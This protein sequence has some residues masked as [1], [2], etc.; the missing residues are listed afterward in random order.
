M[1][2][3]NVGELLQRAWQADTAAGAS[4]AASQTGFAQ[5][6]GSSVPSCSETTDPIS[7][8]FALPSPFFRERKKFA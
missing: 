8:S 7:T 3:W 4:Q 5:M 1:Q 6:P 2:I